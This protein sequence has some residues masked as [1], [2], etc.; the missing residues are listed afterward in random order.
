VNDF[1]AQVARFAADMIAVRNRLLSSPCHTITVRYVAEVLGCEQ[2]AVLTACR[3]AEDRG[4]LELTVYADDL[5][6]NRYH[7]AMITFRD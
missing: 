7:G 6:A 1:P 5:P 2:G 4:L 3:K